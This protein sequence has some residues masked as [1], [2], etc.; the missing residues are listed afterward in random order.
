MRAQKS[1]MST[2]SLAPWCR[3][4]L[5]K[6]IFRKIPTFYGT[7]NFYF[8]ALNSTAMVPIWTKWS[9]STCHHPNV[10]LHL[11]LC[12]HFDPQCQFLTAGFLIR[13]CNVSVVVMLHDLN[14]V[15][16][17]KWRPCHS[18]HWGL[19]L[20]A[21]LSMWNCNEKSGTGTGCSPKALVILSVLL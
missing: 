8:C 17:I 12:L 10:M 20:I 9:N 7:P 14:F 2:N 3:V 21:G 5:Q 4:H 13:N 1:K 19:G 16:L 15:T 6:P 18:H 11:P